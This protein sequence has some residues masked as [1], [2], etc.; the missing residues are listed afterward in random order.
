[1][2]VILI[3]LFALVKSPMEKKRD[4]FAVYVVAG[5]IGL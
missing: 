2:I 3:I 4:S 5:L 1:M